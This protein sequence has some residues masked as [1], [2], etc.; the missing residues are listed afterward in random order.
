LAV[1]DEIRAANARFNDALASGS[2]TEI[3][4]WYTDAARLLA[5]G[6]PRIEGRAAIEDFFRYAI[7]SGF[8]GLQLETDE[9]IEAGDLVIEIGRANPGDA[10][11]GQGKYVVVWRREAGGLKI[12]IDMFNSDSRSAG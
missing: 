4:S 5:D 6:T 2:A 1:I 9:V 7:E 8:N 3:A 10:G 11:G 12:D